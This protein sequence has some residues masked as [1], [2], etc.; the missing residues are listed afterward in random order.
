MNK[1]AKEFLK[2]A[3]KEGKI[4]INKIYPIGKLNVYSPI[5]QIKIK[6]GD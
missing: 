2:A 5:K 1:E 3:I 6:T 4:Y